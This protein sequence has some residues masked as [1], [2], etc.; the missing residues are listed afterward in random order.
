MLVPRF[1]L[2]RA[3]QGVLRAPVLAR[4]VAAAL[5]RRP[6]LADDLV[7]VTSGLHAPGSLLSRRW[8]AALALAAVRAGEESGASSIRGGISHDPDPRAPSGPRADPERIL[9]AAGPRVRS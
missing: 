5:E 1:A 8:L 3:I 9:A 6:D 7:A 4:R 2:A